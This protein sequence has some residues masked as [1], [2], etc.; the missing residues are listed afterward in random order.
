[1]DAVKT[2]AMVAALLL[3]HVTTALGAI[4]T[5]PLAVHAGFDQ[6]IAG[7][8]DPVTARVDIALDRDA[9]DARS[10]HVTTDL[11]PL[12]LL[13]PARTTRTVAGRLETVTIVQR[14]ACLTAPCLASTLTLHPVRVSVNRRD[15]G[16]SAASTSL[17]LQLRGRVSEKDLTTASPH[18]VA[19]VAPPPPS[20]RVAPSSAALLLDVVAG[21]AIAGA[22]ALLALQV[23]AARHRRHREERSD[24]LQRALHLVREA[25]SRPVPDRRRALALLAR[26]LRSRDEVL[27]HEASR[28]AWSAPTPEP[29][30]ID[31]LVTDVESERAG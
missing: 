19:D 2:L 26:L 30:A 12:T 4:P 1:M 20:Y 8:G 28:L 11:A 27:G 25:Q 10:L 6:P 13:A 21:L 22:V 17:Q 16:V 24:E 15:G 18:F 29:P 14:A 5:A 3:A 31:A 23:L 7:F 9:V